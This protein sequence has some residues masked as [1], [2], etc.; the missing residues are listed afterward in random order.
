MA[1]RQLLSFDFDPTALPSD[2][3]CHLA[4]AMFVSAGLPEGVGQDS[5]RR[6]ILAVRASMPDNSYHNFFH[7]IDV[8]QTTN[9]LA[10]ASGVMARLDSWER[11]ALLSAA[12]W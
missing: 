1:K 9:A 11:F 4:M 2:V 5:V 3:L 6:L 7:A 12:F 8:L 10:T